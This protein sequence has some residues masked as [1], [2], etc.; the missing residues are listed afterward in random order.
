MQACDLVH[1]AALIAAHGASGRALLCPVS[2]GL[3]TYWVASKC[4]WDR[5]RRALPTAHE[6]SCSGPGTN[7]KSLEPLIEEILLSEV[8]T[9]VWTGYLVLQDRTRN[10]REAE[11]IA[12]SVL[13]SH[14]EARHRTLSW[15]MHSPGV[16]IAGAVAINQLRRKAER[17]TDLLLGCLARG[18]LQDLAF[19]LQRLDDFALDWQ[20]HPAGTISASWSILLTSLREAFAP[21]GRR[22]PNADLN[23][24]IA[25]GILA[26]FPPELFD[27]T[28]LFHSLWMVRLRYATEEA[29]GM[30]EELIRT[31]RA[32]AETE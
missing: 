29:E 17:W 23:E 10:G 9:R 1:L 12:R 22:S 28:G 5:W 30:L 27:S 26:C 18:D 19:D 15:M 24:R 31:E 20:E 7:W 11:P 2:S 4:R 32:C 14:L 8:L 3:T 21:H 16:P 13:A 6:A 25:A